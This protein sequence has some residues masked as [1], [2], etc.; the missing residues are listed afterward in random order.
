MQRP[1][2]SAP[3]TRQPSQDELD[4]LR[5]LQVTGPPGDRRPGKGRGLTPLLL[6]R[7]E[8]RSRDFGWRD[9][10]H[11]AWLRSPLSTSLS[12]V[13]SPAVSFPWVRGQDKSKSKSKSRGRLEAAFRSDLQPQLLVEQARRSAARR[14]R[15]DAKHCPPFQRAIGWRRVQRVPWRADTE[16]NAEAS[17]STD[18]EV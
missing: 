8:S 16:A 12:L 15:S 1:P 18:A 3:A 13:T 11:P 9:C 10:A 4:P 6:G 2:R 17:L 5:G 7:L 14:E